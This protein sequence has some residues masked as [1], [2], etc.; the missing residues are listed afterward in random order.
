MFATDAQLQVGAGGAAAG[1]GN[2][3]QFAH[4]FFHGLAHGLLRV[5]A[6]FLLQVADLDTGLR[7]GFAGEVSVHAGHDAQHGRFTGAV[8][9]EQADLGAREETERDVF[10]DFALRRHGLGDADHGVNVLHGDSWAKP[11]ILR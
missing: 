11:D 4:A 5:Q 9:A 7:A 1:G 3:N 10:D 8:Q 2:L 6:R